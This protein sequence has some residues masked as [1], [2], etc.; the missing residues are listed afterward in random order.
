MNS[1]FKT[2]LLGS[3][4][5]VIG[6]AGIATSAQAQLDEIIVT[7]Q[8]R[9]QNL[10]DVPI[11]V[12]AF[13]AE[14]LALSGVQNIEDLTAISPG[15]SINTTNTPG[16]TTTIR[17]RGIGTTG[18]NPGLEAAVGFF[19]DGVY[20]SRSGT[21]INDLIDIER[22]EVLRGA[23]GTLFGKNTSAG[24]IHVITK[25]P[26]DEFE[27]YGDV[28]FGNFNS[29]RV[30]GVVNVPILDG[31][32]AARV[33]AGLNR[34]DGWL[35][36]EIDGRDHNDL[37]RWN[38]RGQLLYTPTD[39]IELR[40]IGEQFQSEEDFG[41]T[42][43]VITNAATAFAILPNGGPEHA[44][45]PTAVPVPGTATAN[46]PNVGNQLDQQISGEL[47]WDFGFANLTSITAYRYNDTDTLQDVDFINIDV[48][49]QD[50]TIEQE[51]F[52]QE[53]RLAGSWEDTLWTNNIDWTFG[54]FYS[55]ENIGR[56]GNLDFQTRA[57]NFLGDLTAAGL[58]LNP[59]FT[60]PSTPAEFATMR[61]SLNGVLGP[62][63]NGT[64]EFQQHSQHG[65]GWSV[66][67]HLDIEVLDWLSVVGGARY[68]VERKEG[69]RV[70]S[71][72]IPSFNP[73]P[74][75]IS[76]ATCAASAALC[77]GGSPNVAFLPNTFAPPQHDYIVGDVNGNEVQDDEWTGNVAV[78]VRWTDDIMTYISYAHGFKAGGINLDRGAASNAATFPLDS[79]FCT[80]PTDA[81][82]CAFAGTTF[83]AEFSDTYE[84]GIKSTWFDNRLQ[85]NATVFDSRFTNFQLNTFTGLGFFITNAGVVNSRGFELEAQASPIEGLTWT[86]GVTFADAQ[87][88]DDVDAS[89]GSDG[90]IGDGQLTNASKW[91]GATTATYR[92]PLPNTGGLEGFIHGE[93]YF[94]SRRNSGSD[95][96]PNKDIK[97]WSK[98]NGRIG[99]GAEDGTWE[100]ALWCRN[101]GDRTV[102]SVIF[103]S[104]GQAG[105]YDAFFDLPREWG[106]QLNAR[107]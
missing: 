67:G 77:P 100:A 30:R 74:G 15:L 66:F 55:K 34:R 102:P 64:N 81:R 21:A 29:Q 2:A 10:Q 32:L 4:A 22:I 92:A 106:I 39:D 105:S 36:N 40:I 99:L 75:A 11:A 96:D 41:G 72:D 59:A 78:Q 88:A 58:L 1:S 95:L 24:A 12:S 23:Q 14:A 57:G 103:D 68:N 50:A 19:M 6:L 93:L 18:N 56:T 5:A 60:F 82:T 104:V 89:S 27:A 65:K 13:S 80:D 49:N 97:G 16:S 54:G 42:R 47:N 9:E 33:A 25:K 69:N 87:Y 85:F 84:F 107:Y 8:K 48:L 28:S 52:T 46:D 70:S 45:I 94:R 44:G 53:V 35:E 38:V 51:L 91:T 62:L 90:P 3:A 17:I 37:N 31:V 83:G 7:S 73:T 79:S 61:T 43:R 98:Y 63:F 86:G 101:C 71:S 20:R 26:T 76:A